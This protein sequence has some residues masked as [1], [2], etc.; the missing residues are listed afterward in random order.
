MNPFVL[1]F[2]WAILMASSFV[3]SGNMAV[4]ASPIATSFLRF[5]VALG[6]MTAVI[7]LNN[8]RTRG[9]QCDASTW[10]LKGLFS[11]PQRLL[12][13]FLISGA[14]VGFFIGMFV[15]LES[16][17]PQHTSV[18]YTLVPLMGVAV[19]RVWLKESTSWG[20]VLG[21][22]FGSIGAMMVLFSTQD[23]GMLVW[24]KGDYVFLASCVLLA[25]HVV[26]VQKWGRSIGALQGAFMIM[27]FGSL[28][29]LPITLLWGHLEQV[30]WLELGFWSNTLYLT[31]FTTLFTF[32][33]Q[34]KLVI[35]LGA[36]RL[37]AATYTIPVW[38]ACYVALTTLN[39]S[40]LLNVGF[41][42]GVGILLIALYMI[43]YQNKMVKLVT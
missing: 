10:T 39:W 18:L 30:E 5:I 34:Q 40:L 11:S 17:T 15:A 43:D 25:L 8:Y 23:T 19:A 31:I 33:L 7:F 36:N 29:L 37:L 4:Y 12:H 3:V 6:L 13:Y 32:M 35:R 41:A 16:T 14:L 28:W 1:L 22:L 20:K 26:L 27:L 21:F 2:V 38:V 42:A 9:S 24:N